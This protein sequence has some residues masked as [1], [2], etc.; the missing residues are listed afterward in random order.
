M[1]WIMV[2]GRDLPYGMEGEKPLG[3]IDIGISIG[4]GIGIVIGIGI[5]ISIGSG[6]GIDISI[7]KPYLKP[8]G[9]NK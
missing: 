6:I 7:N 2:T 5:G 3:D 9:K 1:C 8:I 4:I